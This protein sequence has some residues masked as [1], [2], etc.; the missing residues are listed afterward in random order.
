MSEELITEGTRP[1]C[2]RRIYKVNL[3]WSRT[4]Q[5]CHVQLLTG[6]RHGGFC[7]GQN[8]K[9]ANVVRPLPSL[10]LEIEWLALQC[11]ISF[12]SRKLNLIFSFA[13]METTERFPTQSGPQGFLAIQGR[14]YHR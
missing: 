8:G 14:V 12:F 2:T 11:N 3:S 4:C 6:E 1:W 10:P 13:A 7:C 5:F 9:Y